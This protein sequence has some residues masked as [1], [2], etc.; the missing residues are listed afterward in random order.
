MRYIYIFIHSF[1]SRVNAN[2][3]MCKPEQTTNCQLSVTSF[4]YD[5]SPAYLSHGYFVVP[6]LK[7]ELCKTLFLFNVLQSNRIISLVTSV[8]VAPPMPSNLRE[9]YLYKQY[10]KK[11]IS[12]NNTTKSDFSESL[13]LQTIQQ[14]VISVKVYL[15]KQYN[16]K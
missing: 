11:F 6:M 8:T 12:T 4:C 13:S 5:L 7:Q 16:K 10:N 15:Y 2:V 14:K 3:I 9:V 1:M